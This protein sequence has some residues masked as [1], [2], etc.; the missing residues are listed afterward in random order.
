MSK[1]N[2]RPKPRTWKSLRPLAHAA[3]MK[4][5]PCGNGHYLVFPQGT[6]PDHSRAREVPNTRIATGIFL[7]V[8]SRRG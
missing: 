3:G 2:R 7:D 6:G 5:I 1:M 8:L 4:M